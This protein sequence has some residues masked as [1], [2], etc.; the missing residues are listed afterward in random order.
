ME[1]R[2]IWKRH[3]DYQ[4]NQLGGEAS[5]AFLPFALSVMVTNNCEYSNNLP[6]IHGFLM[7]LRRERPISE[8]LGRDVLFSSQSL[9][10]TSFDYC[11]L[12]VK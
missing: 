9:C 3:K 10:C 8:L 7:H 5:P 6:C 1:P 4:E 12:L 2:K 11:T